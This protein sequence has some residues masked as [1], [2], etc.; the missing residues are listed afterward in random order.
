M[1]GKG[2]GLHIEK[3]LLDL[4]STEHSQAGV[5]KHLLKSSLWVADLVVGP[6]GLSCPNRDTKKA[7]LLF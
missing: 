2:K 5:R 6:G 4:R 3:A 7:G 1:E